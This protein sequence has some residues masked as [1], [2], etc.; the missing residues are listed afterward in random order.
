MKKGLIT[1]IALSLIMVVCCPLVACNNPSNSVDNTPKVKIELDKIGFTPNVYANQQVVIPTAYIADDEVKS[2]EISVSVKS[3]SGAQVTV[4]NGAVIATEFGMYDIIYNVDSVTKIEH[5]YVLE[6]GV[7]DGA[8]Y[9]GQEKAWITSDSD[10]NCELERNTD[11]AYV[12]EGNASYKMLVDGNSS[13][14]FPGIILT[15]KNMP[16]S[17]E[18]DGVRVCDFSYY[19]EFRFAFYNDTDSIQQLGMRFYSDDGIM[20]SVDTLINAYGLQEQEWVYVSVSM[21]AF[22]AYSSSFSVENITKIKIFVKNQSKSFKKFYF[23]D[24]KLIKYNDPE[25]D[26]SAL[27]NNQ[28]ITFDCFNALSSTYE[29]KT[30]NVTETLITGFENMADAVKIEPYRNGLSRY[31]EYATMANAAKR[32]DS[33]KGLMFYQSGGSVWTMS[34][35]TMLKPNRKLAML[36]FTDYDFS[37]HDYIAVDVYNPS[38][39]TGIFTLGFASETD[40]WASYEEAATIPSK[41]WG[42]IYLKIQNGADVKTASNPVGVDI[43]NIVQLDIGTNPNIITTGFYIDNLRFVDEV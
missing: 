27:K 14:G 2:K 16:G 33:G 23:D 31:V 39:V 22:K 1:A 26:Y 43:R 30:V 35:E 13:G 24:F 20:Q 15:A 17:Q 7:I 5:F 28:E 41:S 18:F 25:V 19:D 9:E 12:I 38:D 10:G 37:K 29:K 34:F 4:N 8:E 21:D 40:G 11:S 32:D 6:E 3:P 36:L 42:T